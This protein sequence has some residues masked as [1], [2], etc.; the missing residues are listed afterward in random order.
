MQHINEYAD[1]YRKPG[2]WCTIYADVSTG[3]VDTLEAGDVRPENISRDLL[4]AGATE[5]DAQ[6]AAQL[7]WTAK[8]VPGQVSR[9]VLIHNG[10]VELNEVLPGEPAQE[11]TCVASIPDLLPLVQHRG[12]EFAYIVAEVDRSGGEIRLHRAG[13]VQPDNVSGVEGSSQHIRKVPVGGWSQARYQHH[14]EEV[15]KRNADSVA[16][17]IDV[18]AAANNA[19]LI[20]VG[21]DIRARE[22]V[23][24]QLSE[25][26]RAKASTIDMHSKNAGADRT[27]FDEE[28]RKRVAEYFAERYQEILERLAVQD[29]QA[30]PLAADGVGQVV[31]ALQQAQVGTLLLNPA[32]LSGR[33]LLV[34]DAEPWVATAPEEALE[35][36]VLGKESAP[37]VLLRAAALTDAQVQLM[38]PGSLPEGMDLAGLLRWPVGPGAPSA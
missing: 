10:A 24:K 12:R 34:L 23:V 17:E 8:G 2:P 31:H 15:W 19:R 3:T 25:A 14:V 18:L 32:A 1:L 9:F 28:V 36:N 27:V 7:E 35:A 20:L 11:L 4:A 37:A 30:N 33:T 26:S 5:A 29:G 38:P 16:G 6:A 22:L 21:G 13:R